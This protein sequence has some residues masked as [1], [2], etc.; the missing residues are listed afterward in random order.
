MTGHRMLTSAGGGLELN[1]PLVPRRVPLLPLSLSLS[2]S[3]FLS[4]CLSV[5]LLLSF[6][7]SFEKPTPS[8]VPYGH[9]WAT[10]NQM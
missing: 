3:F 9:T 8:L 1:T 7:V 6:C 4:V 2:F 10:R 5:C